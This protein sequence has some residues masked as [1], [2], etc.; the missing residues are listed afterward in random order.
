MEGEEPESSGELATLLDAAMPQ[1]FGEH[2]V[3]HGP[4]MVT[5]GVDQLPGTM[6]E[7]MR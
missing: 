6:T 1:Q 4:P 3:A 5:R 7:S 2:P